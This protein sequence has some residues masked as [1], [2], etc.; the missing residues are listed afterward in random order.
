MIWN[1]FKIIMVIALLAV[2]A[3]IGLSVYSCFDRQNVGQS[4]MPAQK[5]A[6]HS[7]YIENTGKLILTSDYEVHGS[8][9]GSRV[10]ILKGFWELRGQEF[11]F[12]D[13]EIVLDEAIFGEITIK[14]R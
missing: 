2:I 9:V 3:W 14:R 4:N 13:A 8:D 1:L 7:V 11:E 6:S 12:D 5:E 10:F